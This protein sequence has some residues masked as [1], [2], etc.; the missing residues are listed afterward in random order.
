MQRCGFLSVVCAFS[1][2]VLCACSS[3][4]DFKPQYAS[5]AE[6][7]PTV[8]GVPAVSGTT[9]TSAPVVVKAASDEKDK[10]VSDK[11]SSSEPKP[12]VEPPEAKQQK[13]KVKR[14]Y[15]PYYYHDYYYRPWFRPYMGWHWGRPWRYHRSHSH[16]GVG[17]GFG[18]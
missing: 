18:F 16:F 9:S 6:L 3:T 13:V 4:V 5:G 7:N 10:K 11:L 8:Q 15:V 12:A 2:T 14:V 17:L 1:I